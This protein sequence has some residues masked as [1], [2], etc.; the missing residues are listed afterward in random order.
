MQIDKKDLNL[1]YS[2]H[3]AIKQ[4]EASWVWLRSIGNDEIV[5]IELIFKGS[6]ISELYLGWRCHHL[7]RYNCAWFLVSDAYVVCWLCVKCIGSIWLAIHHEN[8][9][10]ADANTDLHE[11]AVCNIEI[12][13][14]C[15]AK[16]S[17][18]QAAIIGGI[19]DLE[20]SIKIDLDGIG[21][22]LSGLYWYAFSICCKLDTRSDRS[23]SF[24]PS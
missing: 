7:A 3:K 22:I 10:F 21:S 1:K 24:T 5:L 14:S 4:A 11:F 15:Y 20:N 8:W 13:C 16:L 9:I 18:R 2:K 23:F 6:V 12:A 19:T 17:I